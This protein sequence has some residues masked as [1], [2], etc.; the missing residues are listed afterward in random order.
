MD[1]LAGRVRRIA[2]EIHQYTRRLVIS[3]VAIERYKAVKR[4]LERYGPYRE[5]TL[6]EKHDLAERLEEMNKRWGLSIQTCA[7]EV[8]LKRFGIERGHCIDSA[9]LLSLFPDDP[10]MAGLLGAGGQTDLVGN[11]STK[12]DTLKDPGQRTLCG[13]TVAKDIGQYCTCMHLCTYCYANVSETV[14]RRNCMR[15]RAQGDLGRFLDTIVP[16][17][18]DNKTSPNLSDQAANLLKEL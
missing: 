18:K 12:P 3:F 17:E 6:E 16:S 9:L 13:C 10:G 5:F 2:D 1:D 15:Y 8:D 14:V 4:R 11:S 7:E